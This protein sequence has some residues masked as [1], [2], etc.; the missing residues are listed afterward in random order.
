M[1]GFAAVVLLGLA[2]CAAATGS[3]TNASSE[4]RDWQTPSGNPPSKAE[5]VAL[6]AACQ[7]ELKTATDSAPMSGCLADLGLRR[8]Q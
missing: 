2:A 7:D 8:I 3:S 1:R 5:F 4:I 6:V